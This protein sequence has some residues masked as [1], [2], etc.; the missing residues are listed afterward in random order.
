M[1]PT[2]GWLTLAN[3]ATYALMAW[4]T[5][6]LLTYLAV[7]VYLHR[8]GEPAGWRF[9]HHGANAILGHLSFYERDGAN[10]YVLRRWALFPLFWTV[11]RTPTPGDYTNLETV[12]RGPVWSAIPWAFSQM[13][14]DPEPSQ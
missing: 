7:R 1:T 6:S 4:I 8:R 13:D 11:K 9:N 3:L 5:A 14:A 2:G 12:T 10:G